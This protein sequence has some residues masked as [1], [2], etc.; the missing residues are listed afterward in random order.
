MFGVQGLR[1]TS[2]ITL[3][4]FLWLT[5]QPL[6]ALA[7]QPATPTPPAATLEDTLDDLRATAEKAESKA[8]RGKDDKPEKDRLLKHLPKLD[9]LESDAEADFAGVEAHLKEHQLPEEI[10]A[11]H[12]AAVAEF[13]ARMGELKRHLRELD[14]AHGRKDRANE[15][16]ALGDLTT[17]LKKEQKR[18][19]QQPF[20]PKNLP[21]RTPDEKVRP[22]K[23]KKEELEPLLHSAK[24]VQVAANDLTPGL[25]AQTTPGL[26]PTAEDLAETEDVQITPA[27][28]FQASVLHHNPVEIW[29]WVRNSIEFVPTYG[30][31]QGSQLTLETLRGNA[32]DTASLLIALL[33]ASGIPARYVYGTIQ[34]PADQV[35]NWV[36][37]V[38]T[39]EAAQNLLGQ[40]GIPTTALV[41]GG[42]IVAF[43]LEH[44]WVSAFVDYI[45]SRGAVN[46]QGDTW[47]PLDGS[48]KQ[49]TY[50]QGLDLKTAVPLDTPALVD[51]IQAGATLNEAE[52]WIQNLNSTALQA[53]LTDYQNRIK[54][55][56]DG[57]KPDA[58]IGDVLGTKTIVPHAYPILMGTLPYQTIATGA[59]SAALPDS[60]RAKY[61]YTL[62]TGLDYNPLGGGDIQRG[63]EVFTHT[64]SLPKLAG[65]KLTLSFVPATQADTDLISSYLPKPHPDGSPIQPGE[66][67]TSLPGYLIHL[68]AEYRID[69]QLVASGGDFTMGSSY[70]GSSALY[71]PDKGWEEAADNVQTAGEY[72]A[73]YVGA[74]V[75]QSKLK[76]LKAKLEGTKTKFEQI[77]ANP[78]D[79]TPIT[80]LTREDFTGEL[81]F[82]TIL[83][84]F[85]ANEASQKIEQRAAQAVAYHKSGFGHFGLSAKVVYRYGIPR[86]VSF[87]SLIMD[88]DYWRD[89][90]VIKDN[91]TRRKIAYIRQTGS[92]LS[93]YE[94]LIPENFWTN[95]QTPGEGI[96]AVKALA[97]AA[98][99]GQKIY[100]LTSQNASILSQI[101]IDDAIRMEIQNAL[102]AGRTV[103]VHEKPIM[104]SGWSGSGYIIEDPMTGAGAYKIS[105][106]ANGGG[107]TLLVLGAFIGLAIAEILFTV[108]ISAAGGP[109]A[110]GATAILGMYML[111][112]LAPVLALTTLILQ[113]ANESQRTCFI[114]GL[115]LGL[116]AASYSIPGLPG[117][118]NSILFYV[119]T[120]LGLAIPSTGDIGSC[121]RA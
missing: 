13:R 16:R 30:S 85:D 15:Q 59:V 74:T 32:F 12:R 105:G 75:S 23:E 38:T 11:R 60:L 46:R 97:K 108:A 2:G 54:T 49:Y 64:V 80:G 25:L 113:R 110:L 84:Y 95:A 56:I 58:T 81:L 102:N 14:Q 111:S 89:T 7:E 92:R 10:Q 71:S 117:V 41:S 4:F 82:S 52:G 103:T 28:K 43:K 83:G 101:Q 93:A 67:P 100:T 88:V 121:L 70:I 115:F 79:T 118:L 72:W 26:T 69:G 50:T 63:N 120:A 107:L 20:D 73:T 87:P 3:F 57:Q 9:G 55:Y 45:P 86:Q 90:A 112:F 8:K 76:G 22:A 5:L 19:P 33:R 116:S 53:S 48:F 77:Q 37:G 21:F 35:M 36:G 109:M 51:Q 91:D 65:G 44:V 47:V 6:R 99:A 68:K 98:A 1:F 39:P 119:G 40:G 78:A 106:G 114:G 62:Y 17:F 94:H 42:K 34:V 104:V 31:I 29:N 24:P 18:R 27:I 66:L 61:R 96:S